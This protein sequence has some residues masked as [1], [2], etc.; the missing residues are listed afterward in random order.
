MGNGSWMGPPLSS[1]LLITKSEDVGQGQALKIN[2]PG[3]SEQ[4]CTTVTSPCSS[5]RTVSFPLTVLIALKC[6]R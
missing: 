1:L 4:W 6:P 2:H 5:P 3:T